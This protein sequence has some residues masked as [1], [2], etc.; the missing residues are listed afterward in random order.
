[1]KERNV[2]ISLLFVVALLAFTFVKVRYWE[3]KRKITFKRNINRVNYTEAALCLMDCQ[4]LDANDITEVI[5][6]GEV[7]SYTRNL[8]KVN[9]RD[10]VLRGKGKKGFNITVFITQCSN[11]SKVTNCFG[12]NASGSCNCNDTKPKPI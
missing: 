10:Y 7:V 1:M 3:P 9:C 4:Q 2:I 5:R 6:N 8:Q 11:V 12:V